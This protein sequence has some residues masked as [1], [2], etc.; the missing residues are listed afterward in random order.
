MYEDNAISGALDEWLQRLDRIELPI[1]D[2]SALQ[3]VRL[4]G[5]ENVRVTQLSALVERDPGLTLRLLRY[6]NALEHKRL[7]AEVATVQH[8]LMMLGLTRLKALPEGIPR[9]EQLQPADR[10]QLL[11]RF[12]MAYHGAY[13]AR[14][15]AQLRKDMEPDE[16]FMA[17][18]LHGLGETLLWL[19]APELLREIQAQSHQGMEPEEAQYVVLGFGIDQLTG[20]LTRRWGLPALLGDSLHPENAQNPRV[21][22][23]M[24]ATQLSRVVREGWYNEATTR[25]IEQV[26]SY[27]HLDF[28]EAATRLHRN[29]VEAVRESL[30]YGAPTAA[31]LL[32]H[33]AEPEG[34]PGRSHLPGHPQPA[35]MEVDFCLAP[36]LQ[37]LRSIQAKLASAPMEPKA[38]ID[39]TLQ[40]MH[41]GIGLN[42]VVF[43]MLTPDRAQLRGRSIIGSDNDPV[44]SRFRVELENAPL[45]KR[46]LAKPQ[47]VWVSRKNRE[48]FLPLLPDDFL[49]LTGTED[50][51]AMSVFVR[52]RPVGIFYADRHTDACALDA[53]AYMRFKQLALGGMRAMGRG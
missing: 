49:E 14:D 39:L 48:V 17:T 38:A 10:E 28:G 41:D 19:H 45:F 53:H 12:A 3:L 32:L 15:W 37:L 50:F 31:L 6:I 16:V 40:G 34:A 23:I 22:G 36:Q 30:F 52:N 5:N 11:Q 18:L 21:L 44:F 7:R 51:L 1:F 43:A 42:R 26:A 24:L 47:S 29:A 25:V 8:A 33:P 46:L 9:V 13:Q 2:A 35:G 4:C 20:E 27:I